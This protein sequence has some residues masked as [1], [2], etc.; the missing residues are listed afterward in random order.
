[1]SNTVILAIIALA[2]AVVTG[3]PAILIALRA[4]NTATTA[5]ATAKGIHDALVKPPR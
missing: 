4:H 3:L 2:T 1:M 5:A